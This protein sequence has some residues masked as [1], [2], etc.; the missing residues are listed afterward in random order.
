[1]ADA[2][3]ITLKSKTGHPLIELAHHGHFLQRQIAPLAWTNKDGTK[4][5]KP[6]GDEFDI[7]VELVNR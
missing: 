1:M 7:S 2:I 3:Q 6:Y 4:T 5:D